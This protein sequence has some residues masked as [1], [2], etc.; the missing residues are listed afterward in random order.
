M[1]VIVMFLALVA[2]AALGAIVEL[3][4]SESRERRASR[5]GEVK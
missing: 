3:S 2:V 5:P 1:E 4:G